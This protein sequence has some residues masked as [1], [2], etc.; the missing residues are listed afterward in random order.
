MPKSNCKQ[1]D[2]TTVFAHLPCRVTTPVE[3]VSQ[4]PVN[5]ESE[6]DNVDLGEAISSL[7]TEL[8]SLRK[9]REQEIANAPFSTNNPGMLN[10]LKSEIRANYQSQI[11]QHLSRLVELRNRQRQQTNA[12]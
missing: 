8:D 5:I 12:G 7:E 1:A 2:G 11:D 9:S 6:S 3:T 10:E 4:M